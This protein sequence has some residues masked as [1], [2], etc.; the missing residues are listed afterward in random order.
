MGGTSKMNS[1]SRRGG[2]GS[3]GQGVAAQVLDE[4]GNDVT[5]RSLLTTKGVP[6]EG[7]EIP[8]LGRSGLNNLTDDA[9]LEDDFDPTSDGQDNTDSSCSRFASNATEPEEPAELTQE[10]LD[11]NVE[12]HL[13]ETST[14]TLL[15]IPGVCVLADT[16]EHY[17]VTQ[18]NEKY[19]ELVKIRGG[20][21]LY[22][23][24]HAQTFNFA[25]KHKEV[26]AAPPTTKE[27]GCT[28]TDWD[29]YD[30]YENDDDI[31]DEDAIDSG[32]KKDGGKVESELGKQV[33]ERREVCLMLHEC[34]SRPHFAF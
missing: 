29:I 24:R 28:A 17:E 14:E 4:N 19:D 23:T 20:S 3:N 13:N 10:E 22:V 11:T 12:M 5:P 27:V 9:G 7:S 15:Y 6:S 26:M 25:Q 21:D 34:I 1:S 31:L 8:G 33:T 32:S 30:M 16:P 2:A 18:R